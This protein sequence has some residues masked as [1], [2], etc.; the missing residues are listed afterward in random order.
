M[1]GVTPMGVYR[2][3]IVVVCEPVDASDVFCVGIVIET[4]NGQLAREGTPEGVPDVRDAM[5]SAVSKARPGLAFRYVTAAEQLADDE[6]GD[7]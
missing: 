5:A 7:K 4:R 1:T 3:R 6:G 2:Q